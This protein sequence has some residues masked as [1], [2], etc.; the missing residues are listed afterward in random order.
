MPD[1]RTPAAPPLQ[2][3][4]QRWGLWL[5][6]RTGVATQLTA[7]PTI[8]QSRSPSWGLPHLPWRGH[9]T[10]LVPPYTKKHPPSTPLPKIFSPPAARAGKER[11]QRPPCISLPNP[12]PRIPAGKPP[13]CA[14][15]EASPRSTCTGTPVGIDS[16]RGRPAGVP[17][18][19]IPFASAAVSTPA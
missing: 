11:Q 3:P 6:R 7:T 8:P 4:R 9:H 2:P 17:E 13:E 15:Q 14:A 12:V 18:T 5:P 19:A 10:R 1:C 16:L